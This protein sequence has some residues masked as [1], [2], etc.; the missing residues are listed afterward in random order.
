MAVVNVVLL[1]LDRRSLRPRTPKKIIFPYA[2]GAAA[3]AATG[4]VK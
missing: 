4:E 3:S 1:Q 2:V